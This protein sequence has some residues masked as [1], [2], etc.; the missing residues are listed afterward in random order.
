MHF[1]YCTR[2]FAFAFGWGNKYKEQKMKLKQN[3]RKDK[4]TKINNRKK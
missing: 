4:F 1:K 3:E 2:P